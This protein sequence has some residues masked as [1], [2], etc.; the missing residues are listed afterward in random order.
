MGNNES[1]LAKICGTK[2]KKQTPNTEAPNESPVDD[3]EE[4]V[5]PYYLRKNLVNQIQDFDDG[6]LIDNNK[7]NY[8]SKEELEKISRR[9]PNYNEW[10]TQNMTVS[11]VRNR[12]KR[13]K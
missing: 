9:F 8:F 5:Y 11:K 12:Q 13:I 3:E 10:L 7:D 6:G 4:P 1:R 2:N